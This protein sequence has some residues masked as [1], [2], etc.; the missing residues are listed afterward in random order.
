MAEEGSLTTV[1]EIGTRGAHD[2]VAQ[3]R[4]DGARV[5]LAAT[6]HSRWVK[7]LRVGIPITVL[8]AIAAFALSTWLN[9]LRMLAALP[10]NIGNVVI[11]GSKIK[12]ES[13][14]LAGFTHDGRAYELV[15]HSAAQDL[16][17]PNMVELQEIVAKVEMPDKDFLHLT[18]VSGLYD[19]KKDMLRLWQNIVLNTPAYD[20]WL[21]E[22]M[23]DVRGGN[24]VSEKPVEVHLLQGI[25]NS[26]RM[27]IFN[28]GEVARFGGGV[29]VNLDGKSF[30]GVSKP[31]KP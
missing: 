4:G 5:F 6:R 24:V 30:H 3:G 1:S 25:L 21:S 16:T 8:A 28:S 23:I 31:G 14:R 27:E 7:T 13:P 15:A 26:N 2:F 20:G 12:M 19:S 9:P 17:K 11:S 10:G 18:A 29:V 22:A